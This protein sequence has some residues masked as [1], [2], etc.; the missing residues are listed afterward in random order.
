MRNLLIGAFIG[1]KVHKYKMYYEYAAEH[2][3]DPDVIKTKESINKFKNAVKKSWRDAK[4][5]VAFDKIVEA[6]KLEAPDKEK[7]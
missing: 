1:Y 6:N 4:V 3:E 5:S 7:E 2:P